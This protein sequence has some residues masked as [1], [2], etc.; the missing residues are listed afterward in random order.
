[1]INYTDSSN[2]RKVI[3]FITDFWGKIPVEKI[4]GDTSLSDLGFF[5]DD[6][7][8][9][10]QMFFLKFDI[11]NSSFNRHLYIEPESGFLSI[12][13]LRNFFFGEREQKVDFN[14]REISISQ[15]VNAVENKKW[16]EL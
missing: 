8:E 6:K 1:M 16:S 7:L 3:D 9:F 15:L 4:N 2:F 14:H 11:D 5:G 12:I 13:S 10:M